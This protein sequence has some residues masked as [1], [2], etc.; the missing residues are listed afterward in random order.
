[1]TSSYSSKDSFNKDPKK[2]PVPTKKSLYA[3]TNKEEGGENNIAQQEQEEESID[4]Q[5]CDLE[6]M[7]PHK[8]SPVCCNQC[9]IF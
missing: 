6:P 8:P 1:M 5:K 7:N 3:D 4:D 2:E 9:N